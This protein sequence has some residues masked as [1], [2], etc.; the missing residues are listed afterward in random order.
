[1]AGLLAARA[2]SDHVDRIA[3]I[4]RDRIPREPAPRKGVP[5][6]RHLHFLLGQG[7]AIIEGF[8]PGIVDD[9]QKHGAVPV[10]LPGD[11]LWLNGAGWSRRFRPGLGILS[12]SHGLFEY[13]VRQRVTALPGVAI[14]ERHAVEGLLAD[15]TGTR[16]GRLGFGPICGCR[17][18]RPLPPQASRP[19]SPRDRYG[20]ASPRRGRGRARRC[21][22]RRTWAASPSGP[23][24]C[25]LTARR[26]RR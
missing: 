4:E 18:R 17:A 24:A 7:L 12:A 11:C 13:T 2:L 19:L 22:G 21:G 26:G 15:A 3:I 5:E 23:A 1:M 16:I 9:M 14:R 25:H 8:F 20:P 6:S 10:S